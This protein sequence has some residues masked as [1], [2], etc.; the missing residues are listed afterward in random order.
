[1]HDQDGAELSVMMHGVSEYLAVGRQYRP[2]DRRAARGPVYLDHE[3]RTPS[4]PSGA[5]PGLSATIL[6]LAGSIRKN[7]FVSSDINTRSPF[8]VSIH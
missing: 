2:N 4:L 1:M 8:G 5:G 6:R 3:N 7:R